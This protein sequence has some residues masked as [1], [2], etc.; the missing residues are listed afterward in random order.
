MRKRAYITLTCLLIG[1]AFCV[2]RAEAI[3]YTWTADGVSSGDG[4]AEN[5]SAVFTFTSANTLTIT[6][7]NTDGPS[8]LSGITSVLDGLRFTLSA[9]PAS[10]SLS[11]GSAAG[12]VTVG[13]NSVQFS[14]PAGGISATGANPFGWTLQSAGSGQWLL[15]A[16][17]GSFKPDGIVNHNVTATD[18][19]TNA[20]H[21]PFLDGPVSFTFNLSGLSAIPSVTSTSFYFGTTPDVQAGHSAVPVPASALLLATGLMGLVVARRR[22]PGK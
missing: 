20:Q 2:G 16:G 5:G 22:S 14:D 18:G 21:N 9:S 4:R 3:T 12:T 13:K 6:L 11:G 7:T 15:A 17:N 10:A 8:Q 19:L 1:L